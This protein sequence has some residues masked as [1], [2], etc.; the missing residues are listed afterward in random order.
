MI[1]TLEIILKEYYIFRKLGGGICTKYQRNRCS[2]KKGRCLALGALPGG[3]QQLDESRVLG[4][5]QTTQH[6][7]LDHRHKLLVTQLSVI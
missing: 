5:L 6:A 1:K 2:F 7:S 4:F 3:F